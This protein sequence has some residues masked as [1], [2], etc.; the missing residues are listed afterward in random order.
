MTATDQTAGIPVI[1]TVDSVPGDVDQIAPE[2]PEAGGL[3]SAALQEALLGRW[4]EA[5]RA[6]R[7]LMKDPALHRDPLLGMDEH[8]ER[9]LDQLRILVDNDAI[10]RAFP[11]RFGGEDAHGA[12]VAAFSD[13]FTA[14][15]SLQIKAGVQWGLFSSAILHLGTEEHHAR[16]LP[17]ALSLRL[18]GAFAMTEIGHGSDVSSI[19][20]TATYD[21]ATEEFVVHTPF[22]GAWKD[23]LGNAALHGRAATVF[24]QLITKGVNHGVHCFFVPIRDEAGNFLP[25]VGGEDDG[26]KG[27]LNGIDNG[28]LHFTQLRIPR[29]NLLNRYGD[30]AAD[31]TYSS[32]I[33][34]PGRRFFTM[35]GTLVQGRVSLSLSA[36][37]AS[38]LGLQGAITYGNQRRQFNASSPDREEVLMDYQN[39]QRRLIDRLARAYADAFSS[40]ELLEKFDEV[41]SGRGDTEHHREELETLAA[42]VK[43]TTTWNALDTLQEAREAC[44]GMGFMARN[45][46]TQMRADLDIFVTFEGD[47]NVLLQLVGKRLLTDYSKEFGRLDVGAVSKY[48]ASQA[49]E[50]LLR[51]GLHKVVQSV[52]DRSDE[53]RS[54]NWFKDPEVQQHLLADRVRSKTAD[55]AGTLQKVRGKD[56]AVQAAAFNSRQQELIE[57]AGDHA[58]LLQWEAFTRVVE[59]IEDEHTRTVLT[60]LRDLFAL[61]TVEDDL[62]WYVSHGRVSSQ[63]ARALRGYINRLAERLRPFAQE[64]VEAYGLEPEHLRMEITT[65]AERERQ[66]E[67][68]AYYAE[69]AASGDAP[70]HERTLRAREKAAKRDSARKNAG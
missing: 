39:H 65:D 41:F 52:S 11:K 36:T 16:W 53:R 10:A 33:A 5:R 24:A 37:G 66:E 32:P 64:L 69:L 26:L 46:V 60:W 29:T 42:A 27:G 38:F 21:E 61:R 34:S 48:V 17:D 43:P 40:N 19:G 22:K 62:G 68:H 70:V 12:S 31:G 47:N 20:T 35:I 18:P 57:V 54:A 7:A 56:R 58:A 25:G 9:V 15:P 6:S 28:R 13:I 50:A 3:D 4:A 1:D 63:R 51:V 59:G 67:A 44:G 8:R 30:V 55:I 14:D 45:R 49:S 2:H 23:Y